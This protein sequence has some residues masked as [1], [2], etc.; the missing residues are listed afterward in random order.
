M[1]QRFS[2]LDV[3]VVAHEL[4]ESLVSL[5]LANIYDLS[6]KI[7]LFKFSKP[8]NKKQLLIDT[9]FRCH[10]TD[11]ARTTATAP[12]VFVA[13][14]RKVLKT[15]RLTKVSQ[16]GTDRVLEFQF[17]DGQYRLF[18]EFFASGNLI[19]TDA[20]LKILAIARNVSEADGQEPQRIGLQYSLE[21][22]QNYPSIPPLT[23]ERVKNALAT[24]VSKAAAQNPS[25][26]K[27]GKAKVGAELRKS[28]A[29]AITEVPPCWSTTL[30]KPIALIS[31]SR[32]R[33]SSLVR[34]SWMS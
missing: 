15:R 17:S 28:L 26:L 4:Q 8:D 9:G 30:C 24:A 31:P 34:R 20:D 3:K 21:N 16:I 11:F 6:S 7:L 19:L 18:L 5:R 14:L 23:K 27:K 22:R 25:A 32:W 29:G 10:L 2:S 13:R 33:I 1:K 12:S